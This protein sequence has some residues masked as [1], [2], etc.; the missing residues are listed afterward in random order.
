MQPCKKF[1]TTDD[2]KAF[3]INVKDWLYSFS[4]TIESDIQEND[5]LQKLKAC[6]DVCKDS[7]AIGSNLACFTR[8][9]LTKTFE[10]AL[11]WLYCRYYKH[12]GM[13]CISNNCF[14]EGDNG[15]LA[16][17][18]NGPKSGFSLHASCNSINAHLERR[19]V[20]MFYVNVI[21]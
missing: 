9:Y 13:G 8:S 16:R 10:P 15:A 20:I 12:R 11:E 14:V 3:Q 21:Y 5:S 4:K 2:E 1:C 18:P 6:I 19:C 17:D 7:G